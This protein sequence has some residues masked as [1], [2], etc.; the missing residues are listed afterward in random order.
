M[1]RMNKK[2]TSIDMYHGDE[3][4]REKKKATSKAT[5]MDMYHGDEQHR[6]KKKYQ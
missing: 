4:H 6:E 3:Q 2:A 1:M 5:S